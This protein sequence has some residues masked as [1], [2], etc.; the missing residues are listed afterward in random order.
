[1]RGKRGDDGVTEAQSSRRRGC[2][3]LLAKA[4]MISVSQ[5]RSSGRR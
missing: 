3:F 1:M 5:L 2:V 4:G